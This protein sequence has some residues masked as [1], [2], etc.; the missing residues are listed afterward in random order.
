MQLQ[1]KQRNNLGPLF[2][3]IAGILA[4]LICVAI[5]GYLF[6]K[7]FQAIN[8]SFLTQDPAPS[9]DVNLSGGIRTPVV[10]TILLTIIGIFIA[11]PWSLATAVYLAE[12]APDSR[13]ISLLRSGIEVLAGVPTIIYAIFGLA[14]FTLPGMGFLSTYA[15][16]VEGARAFGRSFFASGI[17]MAI[18]VLP[19]I[20]KSAEE[21]IK[22]VP[23]SFREAAL[24]L[25]VSKWRMISRVVLPVARPGIVTGTVLAIG[26]IAGDTAIVW[27]TL[28]GSMNMTGTQPWWQPQNWL[29]ALKN[30]G[31]TLT[32]YIYYSSPAGEGNSA[33][34]AFGASFVLILIILTLNFL[35]D[36]ISRKTTKEVSR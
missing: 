10:G 20:T 27:L 21:A 36:F 5:I 32:T 12:Y 33:V 29:S 17:T 11:L 19:F 22:A 15:E 1:S 6:A 3:W 8:L 9:L 28:G 16:G 31:S 23:N 26:R 24:S 35:V 34:K 2:C 7:G 30:T 13:M 25:G 18:M 4:F 14:V